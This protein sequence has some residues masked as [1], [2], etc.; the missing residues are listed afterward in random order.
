VKVLFICTHNRCRSILAEALTNQLGGDSLE[1]RSAGS[2]PAGEVHPRTIE[3]LE[4]RGVS[5][6]GLRSQSWDD[7]EQYQPDVVITVC[8]RA[9]GESCPLWFDDSIR[10]HWGLADP[11]TASGS[12]ADIEQ[13]FES[14]SDTLSNKIQG[15]K[16]VSELPD[17][18]WQE[19]IAERRLD[20]L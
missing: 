6:V 9:A 20:S 2:Q 13:A 8:D 19:A 4:K 5:T 10:L 11:S 15:L 16:K 12:E 3:H 18:R 14:C 17:S 7:L 1:A